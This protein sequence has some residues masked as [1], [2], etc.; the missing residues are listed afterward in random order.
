MSGSVSEVLDLAMALEPEDRI[1]LAEELLASVDTSP[2][3]EM[4]AKW[5]AEAE[6]RVAA[7]GRGEIRRYSEEE[8]FDLEDV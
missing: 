7:Y 1:R 5:L 3:P 4:D 8:V 2:A 6:E